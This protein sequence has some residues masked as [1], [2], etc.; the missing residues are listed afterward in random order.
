MFIPPYRT[1]YLLRIIYAHVCLVY[2]DYFIPFIN[3]NRFFRLRFSL[4]PNI[5]LRRYSNYKSSLSRS[6]RR[7]HPSTMSL[8]WVF[9]WWANP[10]P[11]LCSTFFNSFRY[12]S[13][14]HGTPV[15]SSPNRIK[16]SVRNQ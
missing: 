2:W 10:K 16:K 6:L 3:I 12:R 9:Y 5:I 8:R 4:R 14:Y 15:I 11:I 1:R 7:L 13:H